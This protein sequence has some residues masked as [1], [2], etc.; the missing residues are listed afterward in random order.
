MTNE[1]EDWWAGCC[2]G[3][4]WWLLLSISIA[5]YNIEPI[6]A[7]ILSVF[8]IITGFVVL[9]YWLDA[10]I[11]YDAPKVLALIALFIVIFCHYFFQFL[12]LYLPLLL[13]FYQ[14]SRHL[15]YLVV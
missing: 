1:E 9:G 5:A 14:Q 3:F 13:L 11:N 15:L 10:D 4:L 8:A 12:I 2:I 7:G 6:S